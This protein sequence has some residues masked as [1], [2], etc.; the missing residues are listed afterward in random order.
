[1]ES[2]L[3]SV[4]GSL[5]RVNG[6]LSMTP[7]EKPHSRMLCPLNTWLL[8]ISKSVGMPSMQGASTSQKGNGNGEAIPPNLAICFTELTKQVRKFS[9]IFYLYHL[10]SFI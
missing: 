6:C 5:S 4:D 9:G 1:M 3:L 10:H 2:F 7:Q 8:A